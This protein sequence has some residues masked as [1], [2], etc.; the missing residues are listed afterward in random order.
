MENHWYR[1]HESSSANHAVQLGDNTF[2]TEWFAGM[3][4]IIL[5]SQI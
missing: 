5:M 4:Y 3:I 1:D 2:A